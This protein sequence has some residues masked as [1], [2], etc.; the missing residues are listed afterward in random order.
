MFRS[1]CEWISDKQKEGAR[2]LSLDVPAGLLE[3][4]PFSDTAL[5]VPNEVHTYGPHRLPCALNVD[6]LSGAEIYSNPIGFFP[7]MES[8][9]TR[10]RRDPARLKLFRRS[11]DSHKYSNGAGWI[12]GGSSQMEGA[13]L[14]SAGCFF[15]SGGGILSCMS[16]SESPL[17]LSE[18]SL[19]QK[20][21]FAPDARTGA[22]VAGPGCSQEDA[23]RYLK[24]LSSQVESSDAPKST[25]GSSVSEHGKPDMALILDAGVAVRSLEFPALHGTK[26]LLTPHPGEWKSMGG[27]P[28]QDVKSLQDSLEFAIE[29]VGSFVLYKGQCS[30]LLDPFARKA[31]LFPWPNPG[32]AVAGTGDCLTGILMTALC[33]GAEMQE[34]VE[35]SMELL[36]SATER[37]IHPTSSRFPELIRRTLAYV[38][39]NNQGKNKD[40]PDAIVEYEDDSEQPGTD[41]GMEIFATPGH[42]R[43][44]SG[45][46]RRGLL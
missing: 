36:H 16:T 13:L 10:A 11:V 1:L 46:A 21:E 5:F 28:I 32:L 22:I 34:A 15:A 20:T 26:T 38:S 39:G 44:R 33:R 18:A 43:K 40:A 17:Y 35:A 8:V 31:L 42:S 30:V 9:W 6:L 23:L 37:A 3:N 29:K 19:M 24:T 4:Q 41:A 14:L 25:T 12:L 27:P 45:E 7:E 2:V